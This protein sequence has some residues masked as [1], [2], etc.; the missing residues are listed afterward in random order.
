MQYLLAS[1]LSPIIAGDFNYDL[2]VLE[3]KSLDYFTDH[4]QTVNK[5][6][7][8]SGSLI[9]HVYIKK[10]LMEEF[11]TKVTAT[12]FFVVRAVRR[13]ISGWSV[14]KIIIILNFRVGISNNENIGHHVKETCATMSTQVTYEIYHVSLL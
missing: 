2:Q 4:H 1:N 3:N 12:C 13:I 10:T 8:I 7:H 9:G 14:G 5:P 11:S 6:T